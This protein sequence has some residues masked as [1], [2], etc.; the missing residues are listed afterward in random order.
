MVTILLSLDFQPEGRVGVLRGRSARK[1][2]LFHGLSISLVEVC[3]RGSLKGLIVYN[4]PPVEGEVNDGG[5]YRDAK[6]RGIH[7]ALFTDPEGD[8]LFYYLPNQL[9]KN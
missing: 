8:S 6:L 2:Y 5:V 7:L 9:H 4:Y 3:K 1:G